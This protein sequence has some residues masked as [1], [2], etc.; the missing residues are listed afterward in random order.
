MNG[1][2]ER[3][4][5][6][7]FT[8]LGRKIPKELIPLFES[9]SKT[10]D[11]FNEDISLMKSSLEISSQELMDKNKSLR[12]RLEE[13][14][15]MEDSFRKEK[16]WSEK[17]IQMAPN[18]VIGLEEE[19]RIVFLNKA[20]ERITGYKDAEISG[21]RWIDVFVPQ[22]FRKEIYSIWD[23]LVKEDDGEHYYVNPIKTKSGDI[24]YISWSSTVIRENGRFKMVLAMGK[25]VTESKKAEDL[26][27]ESEERY[28]SL[29]NTANLLIQSV[30]PD[31]VFRLVNKEWQKSLGYS[32]KESS[33][34]RFTDVIK[35]EECE[36]CNN[37]F[38]EIT[39]GKDL[40]DVETVFVAKNGKE[41]YVRGNVHP[42]MKDGKFFSTIGFFMDIT[43][44]K[45]IE[46]EL[47]NSEKKY[48]AV[49]ENTGN[50]TCIIES[51]NTISLV[52][53]RFTEL[54]G[55]S[56]S[57]TEGKKKWVNF[58]TPEYL[59][60]MKNYHRL[61]MRRNG[62]QP[63]SEYEFDMIDKNKNVKHIF[64]TICLMPGTDKSIA[65]LVDITEKKKTEE[66]LRRSE[67]QLSNAMKMAHMAPWDFDESKGEFIFNDVFYEL[68]H[69]TAS[70]EDGYIMSARDY[71]KRFVH[72]DDAPM[73]IQRIRR[74]MK[75]NDNNPNRQIEHR[76]IYADGTT[77]YII[78]RILILKNKKGH[79]IKVYGVNQD[80][81]ERRIAEEELK[82]SENRY[83]SL[84]ESSQDAI[85]VMEPPEWKFVN[86]NP[87]VIKMF[88]C[89]NEKDLINHGPWEFSPKFQPDGEL[90]SSKAKAMND[91][92]LKEGSALFEWTHIR[93]NGELF[94][95]NVLLTKTKIGNRIT[96]Q[97]T[98]RDITMEKK[99][100]EELRLSEE[101][102]KLMLNGIPA[103][104][105]LF[106]AKGNL[107]SVNDF[108][109]TEH[110]LK[111][112]SD[113]KIKKWKYLASIKEEYRDIVTSS[114][115]AA[116]KGESKSFLIQHTNDHA[117]GGFCYSTISPV[118]YKNEIKYI[119]FSSIDV[120]E[121]QK[122]QEEL[123]KKI[124]QMEFIG[125]VNL[126]R[127]KEVMKM[128]RELDKIKSA[129]TH[130]YNTDAVNKKINTES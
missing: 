58:I 43:E 89:N 98:V 94:P 27:R 95:T 36:H 38:S 85:M 74:A 11:D 21:K 108:G 45:N 17:L 93:A 68:L 15:Q 20:A 66:A 84:F 129:D 25:D 8:R 63:P 111:T 90:S 47:R 14:E 32:E 81:T 53:S 125:R 105:K 42:V 46:E 9:I 12:I 122:T 103:C 82:K 124:E 50:A 121:Q 67:T 3:Q 2:L 64:L 16:E 60:I 54:S 51:D 1:D 78:V 120:T 34:M 23:K 18:I 10:Y 83:H 113:E 55:Y 13:I 4:L 73:V 39:K 6:K 80:I 37:F 112:W 128:K 65:S 7:F 107:M 44:R 106:D 110:S 96:L 31:G 92:A 24:R 29:F 99:A 22:D 126:K 69:T 130:G 97:A 48:R 19:S 72:P 59:A 76:I 5:K 88:G 114:L 61:R 123:K 30:G 79:T 62:P 116:G 100:Q 127:H 33:K 26:I 119:I 57:E 115:K 77:G 109:K 101:Y 40:Y 28:R 87:A 104:V 118:Y 102:Y 52:N 41:I 117:K 86:V 71:I 75:G 91:K 56:K 70:D 35:K 49:F